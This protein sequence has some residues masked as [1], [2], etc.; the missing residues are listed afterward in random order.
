MKKTTVK[1]SQASTDFYFETSFSQLKE[2]VDKQRTVL[3]T[4]TN[5]FEAHPAKFKGW[6]TI[7]VPAG[8]A[9]KHMETVSSVI[10]QL[11]GL[12][13]DRQWTLV[14]VGGG[15]I[16][17]LAGFVAA[18]Y[19]RGI[20]F[21]FVPT[22]ILA[23]VDASI[24]GKN[25]VDV[26]V[27][28]NMAG[29]IRQPQFLLYDV[30]LLKTLPE[31]EWINGFAEII[32]HACIKDA[33]MFKQLQQND[34]AFYQRKK[35]ELQKLIERNVKIKAKVVQTDEF[36]KADRKL[37]N[38]GHTLGHAI[39][40]ELQLPHGFAI[41]IGMVYAAHL[42]Q[43]LSGLKASAVNQIIEVLEKYGLPT[44]ANIDM[45]QAFDILKMDKKR[46]EN[47]MNYIVLE[48]I[49]SAKVQKID[50]KELQTLLNN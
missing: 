13:A 44:H 45:A 31:Q 18:I 39:E 48:K 28:K 34:L 7:V 23:M 24:G 9:H 1:Y 8:E 43:N 2:I 36:E 41:S 50:L 29:I 17:D 4:D 47:S 11:I 42:S 25:G 16:T 14:G 22:S 27:Y 46:Q 3:L 35:A 33:A 20:A 5:I 38:Y 12:E 30:S 15:V 49:G 37:L 10:E 21:G 19:M 26:G 6:K 40:N 32:K